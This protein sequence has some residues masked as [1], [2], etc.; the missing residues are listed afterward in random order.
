M[1][2]LLPSYTFAD[3]ARVLKLP[4]LV[5][6]ANK[7]GVINHLLLTLEHAGCKGLTVLG[8]VLNRVCARKA[9]LPPTPIARSWR[10]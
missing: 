7:L 10:I 6:A 5:V 4:I 3:F 8:Y 2:P 1:V 9:P